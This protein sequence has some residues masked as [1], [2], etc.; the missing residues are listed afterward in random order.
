MS[1]TR[2]RR[3]LDLLAAHP[4]GLSTPEIA[5]ACCE[6]IEPWQQALTYCGKVMRKYER[7]GR[8]CRVRNVPGPNGHGSAVLWQAPAPVPEPDYEESTRSFLPA[9]WA[10]SKAFHILH[11][12]GYTCLGDLLYVMSADL[13]ALPRFGPRC[14]E[15]VR[16]GLAS[17]GLVLVDE[18]DDSDLEDS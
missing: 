13:L 8:V 5:G 9:T 15:A 16:E 6:G 2:V 17:R 12:E 11:R 3:M 4:E 14:L 18:L 7:K 1:E 10:G